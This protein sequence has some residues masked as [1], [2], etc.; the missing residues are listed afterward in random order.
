MNNIKIVKGNA[1]DA[2]MNGKIDYLIHQTNCQGKFAGGIAG[3]IRKRLPAAYDAYMTCYNRY[4]FLQ[5]KK[6]IPLGEI[7]Q[8]GGVI[9]LHSQ[10]YYGY[11]KKRYTNYGAMA[12]GLQDIFHYLSN[13][14]ERQ[15]KDIAVGIPFGI[16]CGLGGGDWEIV[17][18]LIEHCLAP[19]VKEVTI[20]K[21]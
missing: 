2:L 13:Y 10:L 9:N 15:Q 16:G 12:A 7:S 21:L 3:E 6:H 18:E 19:F 20:Y 11:D 1:V 8:G 5:G 17:Y 14:D 4:T